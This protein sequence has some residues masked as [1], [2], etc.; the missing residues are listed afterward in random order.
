MSFK[1]LLSF[2][3][4]MR[5]RVVENPMENAESLIY[6]ATAMVHR[7]VIQSISRDAK[8]GITYGKHQASAAGEAP[9]TDTGFLVGSITFKVDKGKEEVT[10]KVIASAPYAAHLEFGT[11]TIAP[12]PYM[13][14]ALEQ[15]RK[16][17][18]KMFRDG[19][20]IK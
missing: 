11:S 17:I 3:K 1:N 10:G 8:T 9:A 6:K 15:N 2:Q 5:K 18:E 14:P 19:G 13:Q 7:R 16:K 20:L 4:R 12:R